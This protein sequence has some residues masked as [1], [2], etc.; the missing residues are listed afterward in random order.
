VNGAAFLGLGWNH[1]CAVSGTNSLFCWGANAAFQVDGSGQ[2]QLAP[3]GVL[4]NVSAVT[5]GVGHTCA[6]HQQGVTCW[7]LN[8]QWQLGA[9]PDDHKEVDVTGLSAVDAI[10][11]GWKHNCAID[12]H[13]VKCWG[14]NDR[15][16]L[17]TPT[18]TA[19][20]WTPVPISVR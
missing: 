17:G 20:S 15:G 4:S 19:K 18:T 9:E 1:S 11:A 3:K 6:I 2:N 5:G 10:A 13:D 14:L 7:G 8:D 16:Q 12:N